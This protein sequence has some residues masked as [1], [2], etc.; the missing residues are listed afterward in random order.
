MGVLIAPQPKG[1]LCGIR[2]VGFFVGV[3]CLCN[4]PVSC[5]WIID[6]EINAAG[7][8]EATY[9]VYQL[10]VQWYEAVSPLIV[11]LGTNGRSSLNMAGCNR[12]LDW[13]P[14]FYIHDVND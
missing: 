8:S 2:I 5:K 7:G 3:A 4:L 13:Q 12:L 10:A 9:G 11:W 14:Y 6:W 1:S